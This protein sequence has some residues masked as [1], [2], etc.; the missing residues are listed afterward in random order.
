MGENNKV[1]DGNHNVHMNTTDN[2]GIEENGTNNYCCCFIANSNYTVD[3]NRSYN[4][5][6]ESIG[7]IILAGDPY[8][9]FCNIY[10]TDNTGSTCWHLDDNMY[11]ITTHDNTDYSINIGHTHHTTMTTVIMDMM[12]LLEV[13]NFTIFRITHQLVKK[14]SFPN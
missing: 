7:H 4:N 14:I 8:N 2:A 10:I 11:Q 6:N 1:E 9:A 5:D 13:S 3:Y 12:V